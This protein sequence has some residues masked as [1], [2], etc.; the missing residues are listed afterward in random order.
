MPRALAGLAERLPPGVAVDLR[1]TDTGGRW[2]VP[3]GP[4][5]RRPVAADRR[6]LLAWLLGRA[7]GDTGFPPLKPWSG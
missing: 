7:G 4:V 6:G 1:A 2:W 3:D 5:H